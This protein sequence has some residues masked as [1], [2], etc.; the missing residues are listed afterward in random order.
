MARARGLISVPP[1]RD[2]QL[3][4]V[5]KLGHEHEQAYRERL[6][7]EWGPVLEI[8]QPG[9]L[10]TL[11]EGDKR[12][13]DAMRRG[14]Q[15]IYQASF[16]DGLWHGRADFLLRVDRPSD[17]GEWS[18][19]VV[20]TKLARALRATHVH[21]VCS[22]SLHVAR[23]QSVLPEFGSIGL[24][25]GETLRFRIPDVLA[26]HKRGCRRLEDTVAAVAAPTYP[27]PVAHCEFC[28][29]ATR[30]YSQWVEDDHLS[31]VAGM[32]RDQRKRLIEVGIDTVKSL[33]TSAPSHDPGELRERV[34]GLLRGQAQLQLLTRE[35]GGLQRRHMEPER[36]RGY[37]RLPAPDAADV[38][39]DLEG[40]PF[41]RDGG[42]EYL[43][44]QETDSGD[45]WLYRARWAH[46][47]DAQREAFEEFVDGVAGRHAANRN[48]HVYHYSAAETAA[49]KRMASA[50]ASREPEIDQMLRDGVFVDLYALV[51][52]ALQVGQPGYSLKQ[53]EPFFMEPRDTTIRSGG[54]SIVAYEQWLATGDDTI[55][56]Q[57]AAY[58]A[59]DCRSTRLLRDWLLS[60]RRE[61]SEEF[62]VCFE[63]LAR[64]EAEETREDP[65]WV[66]EVQVLV[67]R[68][69][70]GLPAD[71][72]DDQADQAQRRTLAGL[73]F[74]H[75]REGKPQ[76]WRFFDL[77]DTSSIDLVGEPDAIGALEPD[78]GN[79]PFST[80]RSTAN[81]MVFPAQEIR[82]KEGDVVDPV[83]TKSAG[84][85]RDIDAAGRLILVR[86]PKFDK[87]P[88][89]G[90]LVGPQPLQTRAQREALCRLAEALLSGSS[91]HAAVRSILR[92]D[93]PRID[94]V[95]PGAVLQGVELSV[96]DTVARALGLN[97]SHLVVQGPPGSG[98]TYR[99][100]QIVIAALARGR[101][102][103]VAASNHKA[104]HNV[105]R[106]VE[107]AAAD[108][109]VRLHGFHKNSGGE[110]EYESTRGLVDSRD[111]NDAASDPGRNLVAGTP[112]LFSRPEHTGAFDLMV[113]DEAGQMSLANA[114]AIGSAA[115]SIVLLGDPQQLPQ[116][117]EGSHPGVSGLSVLDYLIGAHATIPPESGLFITDTRRM[118]PE[119]CSYI[120]ET[121]YEGRVMADP[122]CVRRTVVAD[123]AV[124][125][126]GIRWLPVPHA[127]NSQSS[128]E[129]AA[130]LAACCQN[131]LSG[132]RFKDDM[133]QW[134]DLAP[135]HIMIV[136]PYNLAVRTVSEA[137]PPGVRVGTVDKFQ[138]QEA[139]VVLYA[140][141]S[142][143]SAD[144]PRGLAFL[145]DGH[146]LNVAISRAQAL[147]VLVAAPALL[148]ADCRTLEE[149]RL[150]NRVCRLV[151]LAQHIDPDRL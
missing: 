126:S 91:E 88:L 74:Y 149:M 21:Q 89:P 141:A 103:A 50:Y 94:G 139:P 16:Y 34:F 70:A 24:G 33:A 107:E 105:L 66:A 49:L 78:L 93:L 129:E 120:S 131:L 64:P 71:P 52:Q 90:A 121:F 92:R 68:L 79:P 7:R 15:V 6:E 14:A 10:D 123:G 109:P 3:D 148:D 119:I 87:T 13:A 51:R 23:V 55:L 67:D 95:R 39:F 45:Q 43:W 11:E 145:F 143:T 150:V 97:Q 146:R 102:V 86:G 63:D 96:D 31:L 40:D 5:R 36:A 116:V 44:G 137:V 142:S 122:R 85:V 101:R 134:R 128:T 104:L 106:E 112:W 35:T 25:S 59:D 135:E 56:D 58:N 4:L 54:G 69:L 37:A 138:G 17:L 53:L 84:R 32:R 2:P 42:L 100:A 118:H 130:V 30:C 60:L 140:M 115:Q 125:G 46:S 99:G 77:C 18:Y 47:A 151:D 20:D 28:E 8:A 124:H 26:T 80:K 72:D 75:R 82:I 41:I 38:F 29:F 110:T 132:G 12:T 83:T 113:L 57:I 27:E 111:S 136:T 144:A 48:M 98:K 61:A 76:W 117:T 73:L 62:G 127:G 19:E 9:G 22:Y 65:E 108:I 133:D 81:P 147:S 1:V 114:A